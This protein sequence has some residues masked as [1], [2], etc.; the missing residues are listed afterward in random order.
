MGME[1]TPTIE[2]NRCSAPT[3]HMQM[4]LNFLKKYGLVFKIAATNIC[5]DTQSTMYKGSFFHLQTKI[6]A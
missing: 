4:V 3:K 2:C 5:E 6:A 1:E